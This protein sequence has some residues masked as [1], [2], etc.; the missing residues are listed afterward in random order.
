MKLGIICKKHKKETMHFEAGKIFENNNFTYVCAQMVQ[1]D[2]L[3]QFNTFVSSFVQDSGKCL[4]E[5]ET[6]SRNL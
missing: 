6:G 3:N 2:Y 1:N 5:N 4:K